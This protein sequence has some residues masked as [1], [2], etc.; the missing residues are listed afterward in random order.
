MAV[1]DPERDLVKITLG[2]H[3]ELLKVG[4]WSPWMQFDFETE[5]PGSAV[6]EVLQAPTSLSGMVRFYVKQVHPKLIL[7]ATPINIDPTRP[8]NPIS[9]PESFAADIAHA[10][11]LYF[12]TG[13]PQH[14]PEVQR[15]ALNEDEWL[16]KVHIILDQ[17]SK[18]FRY[19]LKNF[20]SGCL[21]FYFGAPDLVSHIFWR[22]QDPDHPGRDP[23]HGNRYSKVI[24]DIYVIMDKRVGEAVEQLDPHD[25]LIV[26][27]DH[28]FCSFRRGFNL[29]SWLL[30]NG[31]ISLRDPSR[32]QDEMY[33]NVDWK[34]TK[35]YGV[36]LNGLYINLRDREKYGIVADGKEKQGLLDEISQRLLQVHD[37]DGT[38][39]VAKTYL[40]KDDYPNADSR[41]APDMLVG[42]ARNYRA[43]WSTLLGGMPEALIEDNHDRW[44]GDHCVAA[45]LVP[46]ILVTNRK[47]NV[48][49][50]NLTD[51]GPTILAMFGLDVPNVMKG[52]TIMEVASESVSESTRKTRDLLSTEPVSVA[53]NEK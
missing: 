24:E 36:G 39:V 37:D 53:I 17:R 7:F 51:I 16:E 40:V 41:I 31:Y 26:M 9:V 49:D 11:G 18:Q 48:D 38:Q 23:S 8:A 30:E 45:D 19:A 35:A 27:S 42:Y 15:G 5:I 3:T 28:G 1:R 12:T 6:L 10:T 22:D 20:H 25:S 13:I 32:R 2:D 50:P 33:I 44:S 47:I 14:T 52:R 21:F 43:S 46:G 4:E 29:N 34:Q